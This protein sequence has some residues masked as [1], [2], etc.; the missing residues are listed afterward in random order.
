MV[1]L[2]SLAFFHV[3]QGANDIHFDDFYNGVYPKFRQKSYCIAPG[4][5]VM[6]VEVLTLAAAVQPLHLQQ[7]AWVP[8]PMAFAL[9]NQIIYTWKGWAYN[10]GVPFVIPALPIANPNSAG[11]AMF[12][13]NVIQYMDWVDARPGI[14]PHLWYTRHYERTHRLYPELPYPANP[15]TDQRAFTKLSYI[16][17]MQ[18]AW[19][20]F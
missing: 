14:S 4:I 7:Q 9:G 18:N 19:S 1:R 3:N 2:G 17:Q 11:P 20:A 15:G 10:N 5:V 8:V 6:T 13:G 16:P 12:F